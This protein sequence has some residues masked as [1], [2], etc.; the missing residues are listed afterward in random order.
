MAQKAGDN[1]QAFPPPRKLFD[2]KQAFI[3][4]RNNNNNPSAK[5]DGFKQISRAGLQH[6][7]DLVFISFH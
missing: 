3:L 7:P 1:W 5:Y 2:L 4:C 6:L